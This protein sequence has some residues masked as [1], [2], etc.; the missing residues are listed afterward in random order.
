MKELIKGGLL[1]LCA[2]VGLSAGATITIQAPE[3]FKGRVINTKVQVIPGD[4]AMSRGNT[5]SFPATVTLKG[6][7]AQ[8]VDNKGYTP[9]VYTFMMG[10]KGT[11]F[12]AASDETIVVTVAA[13]STMTV[14]G[15]PLMEG[16][17]ALGKQLD[18]FYRD[19][20]KARAA[21][22][23]AAMRKASDDYD[24]MVTNY[25]T[26]NPGNPVAVW[27]VMQ[28]SGQ[29]LLDNAAKL[30]AGARNTII[31]PLLEQ[32]VERTRQA[33][34]AE[35]RQQAMADNHVMA[36]AF[37]LTD[38]NGKEVSLSD[39]RGK[40]VIIDFWGSWCGWCIK[41][42]PELKKAYEQYSGKMEI[43]GVDCG[44]TPERW[45][46]ALK[47]YA[48]P[49]VNVYNTESDAVEQL[50]GVQG[51]PTKVIVDPQ[52]RVYKIVTGEDPAFYDYLR[53]AI[54]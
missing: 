30:T 54:K 28:L 34:E 23:E 21:G 5:V 18:V 45:R 8:G 11:R 22:D 14:S 1:G 52:G 24:A 36:P 6:V 27:A 17:E 9:C 43:I 12:Y 4:K 10:D 51:F 29:D 35:A 50:Y 16:I 33:V 2:L 40:W 39:F 19:F 44:D 38:P 13:D 31:Y 26:A 42:F 32:T 49:W 15:T 47:K 48:L 20:A 46:A 41:G 3:D 37:T 7:E 25:I 53:E